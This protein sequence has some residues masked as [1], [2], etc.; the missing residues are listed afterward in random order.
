MRELL[1]LTL[2][3]WGMCQIEK[4]TSR[5]QLS[6]A[7]DEEMHK[8]VQDGELPNDVTY[9]TLY[10]GFE[11]HCSSYRSKLLWAAQEWQTIAVNEQQKCFKDWNPKKPYCL[12]LTKQVELW[13]VDCGS[14]PRYTNVCRFFH[15][16]KN[17]CSIIAHYALPASGMSYSSILPVVQGPDFLRTMAL[18]ERN[19]GHPSHFIKFDVP[20]LWVSVH[21]ERSFNLYFVLAK[22][23]TTAYFDVEEL[24][25][26]ID[27]DMVRV[28]WE[29]GEWKSNFKHLP[30]MVDRVVKESKGVHVDESLY[31]EDL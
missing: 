20:E 25:E 16:W 14:D 2:V 19:L 7:T 23:F 5:L 13:E 28:T 8:F 21:H 18:L 22:H 1:L 31:T 9:Y 10:K 24:D 30:E 11:A 26:G 17:D 6:H 3:V 4:I 29:G 27:K 15:L 12:Q